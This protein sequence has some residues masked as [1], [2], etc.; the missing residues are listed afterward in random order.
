LQLANTSSSIYL[1]VELTSLLLDVCIDRIQ[2]MRI[3]RLFFAV[4]TTLSF[5]WLFL[6]AHSTFE[7]INAVLNNEPYY[8]DVLPFY[9]LPY[10]LVAFSALSYIDG[11]K[12]TSANLV[13]LIKQWVNFVLLT[14]FALL[15][16]FLS[17]VF[18]SAFFSTFTEFTP[19]LEWLLLTLPIVFVTFFVLLL[20]FLFQTRQSLNSSPVI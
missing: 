12:R 18:F 11:I 5:G 16:L 3:N 15:Q 10:A 14:F 13:L 19:R 4:G 1:L 8:L 17:I 20:Y 2:N 7:L 6:Y 9:F